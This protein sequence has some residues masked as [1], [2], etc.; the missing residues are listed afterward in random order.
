MPLSFKIKNI[1]EIDFKNKNIEILDII[2]QHLAAKSEMI[3]DEAFEI[4]KF[5]IAQALKN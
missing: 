2:N 5:E 3:N 1:L 4:E